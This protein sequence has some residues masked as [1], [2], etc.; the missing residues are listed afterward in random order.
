VTTDNP[1][2]YST[3]MYPALKVM[4]KKCQPLRYG[5]EPYWRAP[6][7][8]P[9]RDVLVPSWNW[10]SVH[11]NDAAELVT[12]DVNGAFLGA[13]GSVSIAH[14]N[15]KN[16]G[17]W[18]YLPA[19]GMV[20][21]GYY[22]VTVPYWGG[23]MIVSPLGDSSRL[24][25]ETAVWVAHP[26]LVLLL[27]LLEEGTIG[28]FGI[29]DSWTCAT[30]TTFRSWVQ[31][32]KTVRTQV[33]DVLENAHHGNVPA[34]CKCN[35]CDRYGAFK[36]GYSAALSMMLT[37]EKCATRRPDWSHA[38]YAQHAASSW[39]KAWRYVLTGHPLIGMGAT[40]EITV[41]RHDLAEVLNQPKPPFRV[42]RTGRALGAF[43]EKPKAQA[44]PLPTDR[45]AALVDLDAEDIL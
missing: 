2:R 10:H 30:A 15:L 34:D 39:R 4:E 43:K 25:T 17:E 6:I 1:P 19:P 35:A 23:G 27:E 40:D 9:S 38:V 11:E 32:L 12:L 31:Q 14:G 3:A 16:Q 18:D 45:P 20:P 8:P 7:T 5:R 37:G 24:Q 42:D 44:T 21:P 26:T 22:K 33:L 36:E 29:L 13:M 28:D 41:V